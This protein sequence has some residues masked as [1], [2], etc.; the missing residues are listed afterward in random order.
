MLDFAIGEILG[1]TNFNFLTAI[2][3]RQQDGRKDVRYPFIRPV[4]IQ[5]D[6]SNY[7]GLSRE[8]SRTGIGL[9]HQADLK[10]VQC[11]LVIPM[12]DDSVSQI[13]IRVVWCKQLGDGWF[14][15]GAQFLMGAEVDAAVAGTNA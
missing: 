6:K 15:S 1:P 4:L 10:A 8:I 5:V 9:M 12:G 14:I 2:E 3:L 11:C 13:P 7:P